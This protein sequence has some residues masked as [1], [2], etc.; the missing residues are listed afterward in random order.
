MWRLQ[1]CYVIENNGNDFCIIY[2]NKFFNMKVKKGNIEQG[3]EKNF[4][5]RVLFYKV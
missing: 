2:I 1:L 5:I 4:F 3:K